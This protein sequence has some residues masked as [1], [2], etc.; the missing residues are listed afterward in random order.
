MRRQ[1]RGSS[2]A[3]RLDARPYGIAHPAELSPETD[4]IDEI[5]TS[6]SE[7]QVPFQEFGDAEDEAD[8]SDHLSVSF[9]TEDEEVHE[10]LS[11]EEQIAAL[12]GA[13]SG[14][15]SDMEA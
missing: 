4:S 14:S 10:R 11:M 1:E 2:E 5:R 3:I 7:H 6:M 15:D 8:V 13:S 12:D 9:A